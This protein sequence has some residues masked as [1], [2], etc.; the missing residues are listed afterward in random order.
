MH[1][2]DLNDDVLNAI[3]LYLHG[4]TLVDL[5]VTCRTFFTFAIPH[6]LHTVDLRRDL[7]QVY[8]FCLFVLSPEHSAR[9]LP[10]LIHSLSMSEAASFVP[11]DSS[12]KTRPEFIARLAD[13]LEQ[14][15]NIT[16]L[17]F[18]NFNLLIEFEPRVCEAIVRLPCL[19]SVS[20]SGAKLQTFDMILRLRGLRHL[21]VQHQRDIIPTIRPFQDT[22]ESLST[23][24]R[25]FSNRQ[26]LLDLSES[27]R[28]PLVRTLKLGVVNVRP[29]RIVQAFPNVRHL[30]LQGG[31][32]SQKDI[33]ENDSWCW[34]SLDLVEGPVIELYQ[35]ALACPI[36][37]LR[38]ESPPES[39]RSN[40]KGTDKLFGP[41]AMFLDIIRSARPM[42][43][44]FPVSS[45][46]QD[47]AFF[48]QLAALVPHL[49]VL[50]LQMGH[51]PTST[52]GH[53]VSAF[54]LLFDILNA[55]LASR[56]RYLNGSSMSRSST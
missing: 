18:T 54:I 30:R 15:H 44:S 43:L 37:E 32:P 25:N 29:R 3:L 45:V 39:F 20:L 11:S 53:L 6:L 8:Q 55:S 23:S 38:F 22:L 40:Q 27:D 12:F 14:S 13:L 31:I 1:L 21:H 9:H 10:L 51:D 33:A 42:A 26:D 28:W 16:S 4:R 2:F 47:E 36:R 48:G 52:S 34:P 56:K 5:M 19:T 35:F 46:M 24:Y 49:K 7:K 17:H 41:S 50:G